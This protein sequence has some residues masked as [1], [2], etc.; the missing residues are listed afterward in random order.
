MQN[1]QENPDLISE[2]E[3]L[4]RPTHKWKNTQ[5]AAKYNHLTKCLLLL[6][7]SRFVVNLHA[8]KGSI[9]ISELCQKKLYWHL[10]ASCIKLSFCPKVTDILWFVPN[11]DIWIQYMW[12]LGH[13]EYLNRLMTSFCPKVTGILWSA[14][15]LHIMWQSTICSPKQWFTL[16]QFRLQIHWCNIYEHK[17]GEYLTRSG[18]NLWWPSTKYMLHQCIWSLNWSIYGLARSDIQILTPDLNSPENFTSGGI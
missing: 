5:I 12:T 14:G 15:N 1:F 18:N 13:R 17:H 6:A 10:T 8:Y 16:D 4:V 3:Y 11:Q 2:F 7:D 9:F